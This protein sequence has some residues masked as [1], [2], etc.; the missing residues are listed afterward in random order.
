MTD[1]LKPAR[2]EPTDARAYGPRIPWKLVFFVA[3]VVLGIVGYYRYQTQTRALELRQ[4][5]ASDYQSNVVP[6][7]GQIEA[8]RERIEGRLLELRD[9]VPETW[10]D[11]R[12]NLAGLH[13]AQGVY[14]RIHESQLESSETFAEAGRGMRPD[15]IPR[16]L[17]LSPVSMLGFYH[18]LGF[19]EEDWL[20]EV[21][22]TEDVLRLRVLEEQLRNRIGQDIPLVMDT[23]NSTYLL[24]VIEHGESRRSHPV[25]AYLWDLR[26]DRLL[27]KTR[28]QAR[29][30]LLNVRIN[31]GGATAPGTQS[32]PTRDGAVD[33]SIASQIRA[34]TGS[35]LAEIASELP[36]PPEPEPAEDEGAEGEA[37]E[38]P[39]VE[40]E[41][42]APEASAED[43][44]QGAE[45]ADE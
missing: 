25:D 43:S 35:G 34:A 14:V 45:T 44:E 11:P 2:Y 4:R 21:E 37:A 3:A 20:S 27:L 23:I 31:I 41:D 9:Q 8:F 30:R 18:H 7:R 16:C 13:R 32:S 36:E 17:G 28:V 1:P 29:G 39:D 6:I 24:A 15:S 40:G 26:Q 19:F 38:G 33:C 12:L 10:A 5:I 42:N 22:A